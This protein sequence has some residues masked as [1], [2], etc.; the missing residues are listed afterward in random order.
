ME[1][2]IKNDPFVSGLL[3]KLPAS[4]RDSFSSD[5]LQALKIALGGRAWGV[6][7][8]DI[9]WTLRFWRW[10]Y[11]FVLLAGRNRRELTR[12]EQRVARF[13]MALV[14]SIFILLSTLFGLLI[15]YLVK[16]ALGIDLLPGYSLGVWDW[17]KD[18][19]M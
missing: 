12:H 8:V 9:R 2:E 11:Y 1:N 5:Q 15:L 4:E 14:L 10:R 3:E 6:H 18:S 16:S 13:A 19:F 7:S 17:F